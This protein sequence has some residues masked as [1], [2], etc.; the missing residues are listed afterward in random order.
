MNIVM[1]VCCL[2]LALGSMTAPLQAGWMD[3]FRKPAP[4][5]PPTIKVL[6]VHD[7][8]GVVLEVKGKYKIFDPHTG[9]HISTRFTG[10][11][12]FIQ[13]LRDG[14]RW[15]EEF[16]GIHQLM[17]VPDESKTTTIV[18]G[19]EY[20][21]PIFIYDIGGS[22]SIVNQVYIEDYLSAI[23]P[24]PKNPQPE[25]FLAAIAIAARTNAYY[26]VEN[27]KSQYFSV[28]G[29]KVGYQGIPSLDPTSAME[30]AIKA[31]RYMV[32]SRT[33]EQDG[34]VS[35]F[36]AEWS[37]NASSTGPLKEAIVSTINM[38]EA[39]AMAQKGDHA[40]Q[41]LAKAFPGMRIELIHYAPEQ[42]L[43]PHKGEN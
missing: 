42:T 16:P 23:L 40:A 43:R 34:R 35:A 39:Q 6:L 24:P 13:G 36:L 19:V 27:P 3:S 25:E 4:V 20:R 11:R 29:S 18:D 12:K 7:K 33:P 37:D 15:G 38:T 1:R 10:K 41:I 32:M 28:D 22:I 26:R 2:L 14:L 31:T 5:L 17:I 8:P 21:G 9:E 30:K